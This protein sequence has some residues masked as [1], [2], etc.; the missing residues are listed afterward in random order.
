VATG[1][2][3]LTSLPTHLR[4][5]YPK[6]HTSPTQIISNHHPTALGRPRVSIVAK[7]EHTFDYR[8]YVLWITPPII[9]VMS[10]SYTQGCGKTCG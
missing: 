7:T 1:R 2:G 6:N 9:S 4:Q 3:A 8:T 10:S 5:R